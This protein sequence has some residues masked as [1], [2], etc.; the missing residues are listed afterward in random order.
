[1]KNN[2]INKKNLVGNWSLNQ[3]DVN[4]AGT[5]I[6]DKSGNG[7]DGV[8]TRTDLLD[9]W[10]FTSGWY[11]NSNTTID[12]SDSFTSM[13]AGSIYMPNIMTIGNKYTMRFAGTTSAPSV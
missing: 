13:A 10:D 11:N 5:S 12:D 7:N 4:N 2:N 9:G 8:I 1:M 6:K 3:D